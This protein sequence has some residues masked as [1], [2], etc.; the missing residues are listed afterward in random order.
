MWAHAQHDGRPAKYRWRPLRKFRNS[1]FLV[2]RRRVWL[3]PA[4]GVP[5]SNAGNIG[6]RKTW[7]QTEFCTRQ[8]S[9]SRQEP[10]KCIYYVPVQETAKHRAKSGWPPVSNIAAVR[11]PRRETRWNLLGVPQTDLIHYTTTHNNRFTVLCPGLPSWAATRRN[12]HPPTILIIIQ[13]LSASSIYN[14]P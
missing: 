1:I 11:K 6:E 4:A 12:T 13:S 8:N 9:I 3:T 5:C 7:T 10:Q 14:D 2:P